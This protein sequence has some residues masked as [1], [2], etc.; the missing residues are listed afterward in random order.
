MIL[1]SMF[2]VNL[3][4]YSA[5]IVPTTSCV[6]MQNWATRN[7]QPCLPLIFHTSKTLV[8]CCDSAH[9]SRW[10]GIASCSCCTLQGLQQLLSPRSC[11]KQS[12]SITVVP[13]LVAL[14][15]GS[16]LWDQSGIRR[17]GA[18]GNMHWTRH[19]SCMLYGGCSHSLV[20]DGACNLSPVLF[21]GSS[22][23]THPQP[24]YSGSGS[25]LHTHVLQIRPSCLTHYGSGPIAP[26]HSYALRIWAKPPHIHR[27]GANCLPSATHQTM[28]SQ[29][30]VCLVGLSSTSVHIGKILCTGPCHVAHRAQK[31]GG[32]GLVAELLMLHCQVSR[33]L[34]IPTGQITQLSR[35]HLAHGPC[36]VITGIKEM[37]PRNKRFPSFEFREFKPWIYM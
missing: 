9:L 23:A 29:T 27:I 32:G 11:A 15:I 37:G 13:K 5:R 1:S 6:F 35:L 34:G 25:L 14:W 2:A 4:Q 12:L 17:A 24:T 21:S 16:T 26:P 8:E 20:W 28:L 31:F 3:L 36:S 10:V 22:P 33:L 18:A 7:S 19:W 30:H